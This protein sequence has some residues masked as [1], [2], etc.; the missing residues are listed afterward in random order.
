MTITQSPSL[1]HTTSR[2]LPADRTP[3]RGTDGRWY[4]PGVTYANVDRRLRD[5]FL[6][7]GH[8]LHDPMGFKTKREAQ[9]WAEALWK[10]QR[11]RAIAGKAT[12]AEMVEKVLAW[13]RRADHDTGG[14]AA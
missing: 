9:K 10:R 7:A 14:D 11:T 13:R 6:S 5:A 3:Y 4:A 2:T 12:G 8:E 1:Q